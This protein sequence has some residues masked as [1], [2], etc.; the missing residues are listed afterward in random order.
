MRKCARALADL[1]EYG[2]VGFG[3]HGAELEVDRT[4]GVHEVYATD[5]E[6]VERRVTVTVVL[7]G[8]AEGLVVRWISLAYFTRNSNHT[9]EGV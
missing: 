6:E 9:L 5:A 8:S 7:V 3:D 1:R 2:A 4:C